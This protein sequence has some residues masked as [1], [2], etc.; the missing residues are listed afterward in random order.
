MATNMNF[1]A[2]DGTILT[3]AVMG[4]M[5]A[6]EEDAPA[7]LV[8]RATDKA[9]ELRKALER[10]PDVIMM[11]MPGLGFAMRVEGHKKRMIAELHAAGGWGTFASDG[12]T[13]EYGTAG[14]ML[15]EADEQLR[16]D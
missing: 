2:S 3:A 13:N 8:E 5:G 7:S 11:V 15:D 10:H 16:E 1:K 4:R 12:E 14:E 9:V 6:L